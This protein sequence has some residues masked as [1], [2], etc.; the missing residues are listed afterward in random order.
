MN[1][2]STKRFVEKDSMKSEYILWTF[3]KNRFKAT[4]VKNN[5]DS[6]SIQ[7][8]AIIKT[9]EKMNPGSISINKSFGEG[10]YY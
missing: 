4:T 6:D 7:T 10:G 9:N 5:F 1:I 3:L 8:V 2:N